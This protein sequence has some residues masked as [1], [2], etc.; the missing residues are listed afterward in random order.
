MFP[1]PIIDLEAYR[2]GAGKRGNTPYAQNLEFLLKQ[3]ANVMSQPSQLLPLYKSSDVIISREIQEVRKRF[4][5]VL[6]SDYHPPMPVSYASSKSESEVV[7][8]STSRVATPAPP[9]TLKT[10]NARAPANSNKRGLREV[11]TIKEDSVPPVK[12]I[13]LKIGGAVLGQATTQNAQ[14]EVQEIK[15][16]VATTQTIELPATYKTKWTSAE[17]RHFERLLQKY[18]ANPKMSTS[19]RYALIAAELGTRTQQ[20]ISGRLSKMHMRAGKRAKDPR[21]QRI[22]QLLEKF[23]EVEKQADKST[24]DWRLLDLMTRQMRRA[25]TI[26]NI[27]MNVSIHWNR[28][29]AYCKATPIIGLRW[30]CLVCPEEPSLCDDCRSGHPTK[31]HLIRFEYPETCLSRAIGKWRHRPEAFAENEFAYLDPSRCKDRLRDNT[32]N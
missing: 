24:E 16:P 15:K 25:H 12:R 11:I 4:T 1:L 3:L 18:P 31:H 10:S 7:S 26:I 13:R 30:Q 14:R 8:E 5:D 21:L 28:Q 19:Q 2:R 17:E 29:C 20:Q 27:R 32:S 9:N 22:E 6:G 23:E